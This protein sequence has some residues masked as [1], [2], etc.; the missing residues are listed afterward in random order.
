LRWQFLLL[1][2]LILV[3]LPA[4]PAQ[5]FPPPRVAALHRNY[6]ETIPG[7]KVTFDMVAIP[8]GTFLMGSPDREQGR[9]ADEGPQ[10]PVRVRAFWMGKTEV[11]WD[12]FDL[13]RKVLPPAQRK[14]PISPAERAADAVTR[15]TAPYMDEYC[16]FGQERHPVV[17]IS[18]HAA[19]EYCRWLSARTGKAYRLPTEAEWEYACRAGS[20][21]AFFWG[22]NPHELGKY[23]WF[24]D[25]SDEQ[26]HPVGQK[27][28]NRWGLYDMAGNVAEWC[29]DHYAADSYG[30][31]PRDRLTLAPVKLPTAARNPYVARGGSWADPPDKCRS[32]ARRGSDKHWN[33]RDPDIRPSIWWLSDGDFVGF[34]VVRAVEEQENLRGVKSQVTRKSPP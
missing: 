10:H 21:S 33:R 14:P 18:H 13:Y 11:T 22:D 6:T 17:S 23:A 1:I 30:T 4:L 26:T 5:D 28:P 29:L 24:A 19:M 8:P 7:S 2:A 31:F 27:R 32:A 3:L 9:G 15:P 25:N 20:R 12:E 16:G 34:R